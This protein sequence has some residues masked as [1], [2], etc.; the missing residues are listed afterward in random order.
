M[1]YVIQ[2]RRTENNQERIIT[3]LQLHITCV[4]TK[5]LLTL[6]SDHRSGVRSY[7]QREINTI[8]PVY[9]KRPLPDL[10]AKEYQLLYKRE[11]LKN[12]SLLKGP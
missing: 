10:P 7:F 1:I 8:S 12:Q 9:Y 5:V 11:Y 2:S 3:Q 4:A 6:I